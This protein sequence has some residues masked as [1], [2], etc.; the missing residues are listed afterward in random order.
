MSLIYICWASD[1]P[2]RD[3]CERIDLDLMWISKWCINQNIDSWRNTH[4]CVNFLF[5][6]KQQVCKPMNFQLMNHQKVYL[7]W[8][9][10]VSASQY[11][12]KFV[13]VLVPPYFLLIFVIIKLFY[14]SLYWIFLRLTVIKIALKYSLFYLY[15]IN[16]YI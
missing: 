3:Q 13:L 15:H 10:N 6:V 12:L 9:Q 11:I 7:P 16:I 2:N 1:Y 4:L 14:C 5:L 8:I